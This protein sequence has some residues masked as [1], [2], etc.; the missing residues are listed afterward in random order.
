MKRL[1]VSLLTV[2]MTALAAGAPAWADVLAGDAP[3]RIKDLAI[4]QGARDN[5]LTGLGLVVGL[6]GTGDTI[7]TG[8]T[9][10]AIANLL[11]SN[12]I[13]PGSTLQQQM[14]TK[15]AAVVT[16]TA[17]LPPFVK[18]GEP[19]DCTVA[20][21]GDA[22]SLQN[23]VLLQC[24]LEAADGKVYAV[25][26]GPLSTGGF[27]A[28]ANGSSFQKNQVLVGRIPDGALVERGV[29][30]TVLDPDG[31]MYLDLLD[32]DY[33]T[34]ARVASAIAKSGLGSAQAMDAATVRILVPTSSRDKLVD[35]IARMQSLSVVPDAVA[36]VVIDE[37]TGTIILGSNVT[38]G[39]VAIS[40]GG[41]IIKVQTKQTVSQPGPFS[42][43]TT[44]V[45]TQS[46]VTAAEQ[47]AK[48]VIFQSGTTLGQLVKALNAL[49]TTPRDLINII[50]S[51]KAAGALNADLEII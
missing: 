41:L 45:T 15:N 5:Q 17:K 37:R 9:Q 26:Q 14:I 28:A 12:G 19:I 32:P 22:T 18:P 43:G 11:R 36:K 2:L 20:S 24:P 44:T 39:P 25:A 33:A 10:R 31:F 50:Q 51:I 42:A 3:V 40:N 7:E 8:F 48:T 38:I 30:V 35:V 21:I 6:A 13:Y 29:P 47:R 23:G 46:D 16:V 4:V 27:S 1:L 34:A 49:G